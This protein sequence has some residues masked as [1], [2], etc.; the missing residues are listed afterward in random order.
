MALRPNTQ[1]GR[2]AA[3]D[4]A[5]AN[6]ARAQAALARATADSEGE[7]PADEEEAEE[8]PKPEA[9]EGTDGEA[10]AIAAS[11]EARSHPE[12]ALAAIQSG[13]T[14]AQFQANVA[15][16]PAGRGRLADA[17]A[18]SRRLGADTPRPPGASAELDSKAIYGRRAQGRRRA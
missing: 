8:E 3:L 6:L 7:M 10:Q 17:L 4:R 16:A 1:V 12:M 14:L 9:E 18:G 11:A 2:K 5:Q 15:A 13:Q